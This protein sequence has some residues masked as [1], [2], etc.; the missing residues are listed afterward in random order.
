[1]DYRYIVDQY[2][3]ENKAYFSSDVVGDSAA[4]FT[5]RF[6]AVY[7]DAGLFRVGLRANYNFKN[8]VNIQLKGVYNSWDVKTQLHAWMKPKLEADV[9]ADVRINKN[10]TASAQ[11]FYEGERYAQLG[12]KPFKMDPKVD[13]NLGATYTFNR[14]LSA[15]AKLNNL[16]NSKYQQFY[17]YEVQ[18]INFML[19]GAVSF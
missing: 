19:G 8:T 1:M 14:T 2:F 4:L 15:F 9:S 3:F 10:L 17:G 12:N 5:N 6:N 18:G 11:L 16:L 13:V 7:S